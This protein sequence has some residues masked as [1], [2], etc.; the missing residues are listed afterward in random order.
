[1]SSKLYKIDGFVLDIKRRCFSHE[2]RLIQLSSRAF[3]ILTYLIEKKGEIVEKEELLDRVWTDSFVEESNL[4]VHIS[5]LRRVLHEKKGESK[6]I[7]TISGRGYSFIAPVTEIVSPEEISEIESD[8]SRPE[9]LVAGRQLSIAVLPFTFEESKKDNEYL[10]DGVTRAL[11]NDLSQ[12]SGLKVL[13][14][15]A[16]KKYKG[17][18]LELQE[19]GFLLDA[20]HLLTGHI[21]EYRGRL[22]ITVELISAADNRCVWG[23][24]HVFESEDIFKVKNEI[25]RTITEKLKLKLN[26]S[27][28]AELAAA[29]EIDAE[30]QKLYFRGKFIL[31]SRTTKKQPEEI[32]HQALKFFRGAVKKEPNYAL[33]FVGIGSAYVSLHNH[34]LL[35][36]ETAFIEAKKALQM[37]LRTNDKLSEA[38]VLKGSIEIMFETNFPAAEKSFNQAI[39]LNPNNPDAYHWKSYLYICFGKF[40]EAFELETK[41]TELDPTSIRFNGGITKIFFF[42]GD[43][44]KAIIQAEELLE[45]DENI[46]TSY[47]FI[48]LSYA[49]LGFFESA[50]NYIEKMVKIR[51]SPEILLN[52]AYIYGLFGDL[53][54]A[55]KILRAVLDRSFSQIDYTDVALVYSVL[56]RADE[57]FHCLEEAF[58]VKSTN[59][60]HLKVD[61]RFERWWSHPRYQEFL[62]R[63]KLVD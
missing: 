38:H 37:A 49:R 44:T 25:S 24:S 1:M 52:K 35:D 59:L 17:S 12:I 20:D 7:R 33:A 14:H 26:L 9:T 16:V 58:A 54:E 62:K 6:Y 40:S 11:I 53:A 22:E 63:L 32:L 5:A 56:G 29:R 10:A 47:L 45:F 57:V 43:Y 50:I 60:H 42:S 51:S 18:E 34:R 21:S 27:E 2:N 31:E 19:V 41:A 30:A 61:V 28:K 13:A 48:A 8:Y 46:L 39:A 3:D 23:S 55:E 4:A 15:S 36:R